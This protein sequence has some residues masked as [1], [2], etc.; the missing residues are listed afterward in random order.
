[1][2]EFLDELSIKVFD[3]LD[4]L[5]DDSVRLKLIRRS[6]QV[7][8]ECGRGVGIDEVSSLLRE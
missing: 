3:G 4:V 6:L 1:M 8:F 2:E 5:S 7:A